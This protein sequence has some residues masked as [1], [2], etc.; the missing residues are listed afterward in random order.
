[1]APE[2]SGD[3]SGAEGETR[4]N[5]NERNITN[6]RYG[7]GRSVLYCFGQFGGNI[8]NMICT[9][10]L[11]YFYTTKGPGHEAYISS[12]VFGMAFMLGRFV[13][14][15]ADPLVAYW[16]DNTRSRWGRRR[17]FL[18]F[19][20]PP[21]IITFVLLFNPI[22]PAGSLTI[23]IYTII[24]MSLFYIFF[25][26]VMGPYLSLYPEL[27]PDSGE[28]VQVSTYMA[29][30][31][32]LATAF[33]GMIVPKFVD[34]KSSLYMG[35]F[36]AALMS[37]VVSFVFVYVT[38]LTVREKHT[39]ASSKKEESYSML[40]AF[41]WTLKNPA[42]S[43]YI[44][45][46]VFQY[47]GFACITSSIPFFVTRLMGQTE[48]F[49]TVVYLTLFPGIVISFVIINALTKRFEKAFLYKIGLL[50]LALLMPLLYVVGRFDLPV[51]PMIAGM[52]LMGLLSFPIAIN[53]IL[54]MA[55]LA[56]IADYDEK[57]SGHRREGM[58]FGMQ[59]LLQKIATGLS[60]GMQGILFQMY[61]KE[62]SSAACGGPDCYLGVSLLGP[63]AGALGLIGFFVFLK[64]PLDEKTK[65]IKGR[66]TTSAGPA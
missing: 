65:D 37:G 24:L 64:Y 34:V 17:P 32:M 62:L 9:G 7:L 49:V 19:A 50:L 2:P 13:D 30:C 35:Y 4:P 12:V 23:T 11:V 41:S 26:L 43:V 22:F 47:L 40:Q 31:M 6:E 14:G 39:T 29:V 61:G 44:V 54:P 63:I 8:V 28:R 52:I 45:S 18:L 58:Y 55:I 38:A 48:G 42:F 10:W 33:Q 5:M 21:L 60:M 16:S 25:T 56:D 20:T 27:V 1:M 15:I 51:S 59:G 57:L 53:Q 66:Q 3:A 46:S 36:N